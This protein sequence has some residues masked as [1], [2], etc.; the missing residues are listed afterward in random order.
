M[1][2]TSFST[3]MKRPLSRP[4]L[5]KIR[6]RS[7]QRTICATYL[8]SKAGTSQAEWAKAWR[9]RFRGM[10]KRERSMRLW[11]LPTPGSLLFFRQANFEEPW[12]WIARLS[13]ADNELICRVGP[14]TPMGE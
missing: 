10:T 11:R 12:E 14:G 1:I 13:Q 3:S 2:S 6:Q 7:Q 4:T 5:A 9:E 8:G